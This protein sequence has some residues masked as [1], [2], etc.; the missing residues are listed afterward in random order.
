MLKTLISPLQKV[1]LQKHLCPACTRPLDKA[2][3]IDNRIDVDIVQCECSR[4]F[5]HDKDLD[6]FRRAVDD[7]LT[8]G[9]ANAY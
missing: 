8:K 4:I 7:D 9:H 3:I 1:L 2:T 5:V 6:T